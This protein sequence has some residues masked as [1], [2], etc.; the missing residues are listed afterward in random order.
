VNI[1][2]T[3]NVI[4]EKDSAVGS[5]SASGQ[6]NIDAI[7][8]G[9]IGAV[10]DVSGKIF[11]HSANI[12]TA[13][14]VL[15]IVFILEIP[16]NVPVDVDG[17]G[18][19]VGDWLVLSG[20]AG[21]D[22]FEVNSDSVHVAGRTTISYQGISRL[23]IESLAGTDIFDVS[24]TSALELTKL[25]GTGS[26]SLNL[27]TNGQ[28]NR[29]L[30]FNGGS[31]P[32]PI[33]VTAGSFAPGVFGENALAASSSRVVGLGLDLLHHN[34]TSIDSDL[35]SP[36][37][38]FYLMDAV[39][40]TTVQANANHHQVVIGGPESVVLAIAGG[41]TRT[42]SGLQDLSTFAKPVTL[43]GL[44]GAD[45]SLTFD[46]SKGRA[47]TDP[48]DPGQTPGYLYLDSL[49]GMG[50]G[51]DAE[52]SFT[53][54][55]KLTVDIGDGDL[56]IVETI[57][58]RVMVNMGPGDESTLTGT[59]T[60]TVSVLSSDA[61]ELLIT[62]GGSF[63][64]VVVDASSTTSSLQA[65]VEDA[66][67]DGVSGWT[68][69]DGFDP[70]GPTYI[71]GVT[72]AEL[73][74]GSDNDSLTISTSVPTMAITAYG[75]TGADQ[76][77]VL[78]NS[79]PED[80]LSNGGFNLSLFG[81]A[82]E[83]TVKAI[84]PGL[85]NDPNHLGLLHV[86]SN[87]E[88]LVIDNT[89]NSEKVD[90]ETNSGANVGYFTEA[91]GH[92]PLISMA[93]VE[94]V[95]ILGGSSPTNTL[96]I[97]AGA[98]EQKGTIDGN[99]VTLR[100]SG[101]LQF[102]RLRGPVASY[103]EGSF[104]LRT[105]D[106]S[107]GLIEDNTLAPAVKRATDQDVPFQLN[108]TDGGLF[109]LFSI[110]LSGI[111][112]T[113][114]FGTRADGSTVNQ[115]IQVSSP[116]EFTTYELGP[117]FRN[118]VSVIFSPGEF[119]ITSIVATQT[120]RAGVS[121][122]INEVPGF[123]PTEPQDIELFG[124]SGIAVNGVPVDFYVISGDGRN[125]RYGIFNG[126][127][128][129]LGN[130]NLA[131]QGNARTIF[132]YGDLNIPAN[133]TVTLGTLFDS[134]AVSIVVQNDVNIGEGVVFNVP[135]GSLGGGRGGSVESTTGSGPAG[136]D[137]NDF[138]HALDLHG[139]ANGGTFY[140]PGGG[141]G[142]TGTSWR[143][144]SG[145]G[146]NFD[147]VGP[148]EID[149]IGGAGGNSVDNNGWVGGV[150]FEGKFGSE[151]RN[152]VNSFGSAG[153]TGAGGAGGAGGTGGAPAG[154]NDLFGYP[155]ADGAP[156]GDGSPG[157]SGTIVYSNSLVLTA[158]G[159][160]GSGGSGGGG[161]AGGGG[162]LGPVISDDSG[163][164]SYIEGHWGGPGGVGG[165]G[166]Q[167]GAGGG[168]FA[169]RAA[170]RI[171]LNAT[172]LV[173]R[174]QDGQAGT[175]GA[176]GG[177]P[178]DPNNRTVLGTYGD[179]GQGGTGG[180]GGNGG[181][182]AGGGG[183]TVQ[184]YG[185]AVY[186]GENSSVD[187]GGGL[188]GDGTS[189]GM[190]G[191]FLFGSNTNTVTLERLNVGNE[192][193]YGLG[194]NASNP[195]VDYDVYLAGFD[196]PP[197]SGTNLMV[198]G[199]LEGGDNNYFLHVYD[200]MGRR[201]VD[202]T[203]RS[204]VDQDGTYQT[205]FDL[206]LVL[207]QNLNSSGTVS[208]ETLR[209]N[210]ISKV[211]NVANIDPVTPLIGG[212]RGGAN[213][214]G[215]VADPDLLAALDLNVLYESAISNAPSD[216]LATVMRL[217]MP[218]GFDQYAGFDLVVYTNLTSIPL[219]N[220]RLGITQ[221]SQDSSF[222]R[223]LQYAGSYQVVGQNNFESFFHNPYT[224]P[225]PTDSLVVGVT[226]TYSGLSQNLGA[227]P[228]HGIF[229]TLI[230][231]E[232]LREDQDS[233][234]SDNVTVGGDGVQCDYVNASISGAVSNVAGAILVDGNPLYITLPPVARPDSA[235]QRVYS[236]FF[237]SMDELT[238]TATGI[239]N[240][241]I[242]QLHS[243]PVSAVTI[244]LTA[245]TGNNEVNLLEFPPSSGT[246]ASQTI[247]VYTGVGTD[248]VTLYAAQAD[249]TFNVNTGDASD[250]FV[251][252]G[253]VTKNFRN[254][255]RVELGTGDDVA[256]VTSTNLE[257]SQDILLD[258]GPD[259]DRLDY[260]LEGNE[261]VARDADNVLVTDPVFPNGSITLAP[262][263]IVGTVNYRN[264]EGGFDGLSGPESDPGVYTINQGES[265]TLLGVATA[266][267]NSQILAISWDLDGDGFYGDAFDPATT[268]GSEAQSNPVV[269]WQRLKDLGLGLADT[270]IISMEVT[271][272]NGDFVEYT[273][274]TVNRVAPVI[275][276]NAPDVV[277]VGDNIAA[278]LG[279]FFVGGERPSVASIVWDIVGDNSSTPLPGAATSA[280]H[281]YRNVGTYQ[282][283]A[284]FYEG[285]NAYQ[286]NIEE[287]EVIVDP[288]SLQIGGPYTIL[289]GDGVVL[290]AI[291]D[292][293]PDQ[294]QWDL[295]G[296]GDYL[297]S[298]AFVD[299]GNGTSTSSIALFWS[300]LNAAGITDLGTFANVKVRA[301]YPSG[302]AAGF[303]VS[304][305]TSLTVNDVAPTAMLTGGPIGEGGTGSVT[306][307]RLFHPSPEVTAAGFRYSYDFGNTG[308]YQVVDSSS[309]T[310]TIP[311]ELLYQ[312]GS[313]PVRGRI[314][315][316]FGTASEYVI[317]V[318]I[319]D[320][321]PAFVTFDGGKIVN[322]GETVS[323]VNVS[324]TDPGRDII[325]ATINWGDGTSTAG[326]VTLTNTNPIPTTGT[327]SGSHTF[328][329]R[330]APYQVSVTITDVSGLSATRTFE[331]TVLDPVLSSVVA[332]PDQTIDE[333]DEVVLTAAR[334]I[335]PAAPSNYSVS[336]DWGDGTVNNS[337]V[338]SPPS[339]P[340]DAGRVFDGHYYGQ[341]GVYVVKMT[342]TKVGQ[343]PIES[344]FN[345]IV[346]NVIP[347]VDAGEDVAAGPGVPVLVNATFSDPSFLDSYVATID[348][349]DGTTS[350]GAI[351]LSPGSEGAPT[352]GIVT[353]S[354]Q[355][356][357]NGPHTVTVS[358]GD[359]SGDQGS[360][361]FQVVN[362][363]PEI[364]L[365]QASLEDVEGNEVTLS[366][367]FTDL[368]FDY[369]GTA[370][371]FTASIDWGDGSSVLA[372]Y[373]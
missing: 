29:P 238:V 365:N 235:E 68:K 116:G 76:F 4:L 313:L 233:C 177:V 185:T 334:F 63:N 9:Q 165:V 288:A 344:T 314:A 135:P 261:F 121:R 132:F 237:S 289:A 271:T 65:S 161:G 249:H 220:P 189:S 322:V 285:G 274:L 328:A 195:D 353:G 295:S 210:I 201:I 154:E 343:D 281:T 61:T 1:A 218:D 175:P 363:Q 182:G 17:G 369:S 35:I 194:P 124:G 329:Y 79:V 321:P 219:A 95:D 179:S 317:N 28:F 348:W 241:V 260:L 217:D 336:V 222:L 131:D 16:A 359:G 366:G 46:N 120:L 257:T 153:A 303:L 101:L 254:T 52:F 193:D 298:S 290:T 70:I 12:T 304:Q 293:A 306:F 106:G 213:T 22:T 364:T 40:E 187:V 316:Q 337:P 252:A 5:N 176:A 8:S 312:V 346:N 191:Q 45:N 199:L 25:T 196:P 200:G 99:K 183:G 368:G 227:L 81:A 129:A 60:N 167:G 36:S 309:P 125:R 80:L 148:L 305:P 318:P 157:T 18:G 58:G 49:E 225:E 98:V 361:T 43:T 362:S 239:K 103:S 137:P 350:P 31:G 113:S 224:A 152:G 108:A 141:A 310:H 30:E 347:R 294:A 71:K 278:S 216:A 44:P 245:N 324:F 332:G 117:E 354:H 93:R 2:T 205:A 301:N 229:V 64:R 14:N 72:E 142:G 57:P 275:T 231:D 69:L 123:M 358:V 145:I 73:Y 3:G 184:L 100:S 240:D 190:D 115:S 327:I 139:G 83:D 150:G 265:V 163:T 24:G 104:T 126:T 114:F 331:V 140:G 96:T 325:S 158:G 34:A 42:V 360:D 234:A 277:Y 89:A 300:Q 118:L 19:N 66:I 286:S 315:D 282:V 250:L 169:I 345:V 258:G 279:A 143:T 147:Y 156:G 59:G 119:L 138:A 77:D 127:P 256:R 188:H 128:F 272:T 319:N 97:N 226:P 11:A 333:G 267:T 352:T 37:S 180:A 162:G 122:Q 230:P 243:P 323:L 371:S 198:L 111:G 144:T 349:G 246:S 248:K 181:S 133:S 202:V 367:S 107:L 307:T 326:A 54:F 155:G 85:P 92:T 13:E 82:G 280:S 160:G 273:T 223:N 292:G 186:A 221:G 291:A 7:V 284:T 74:L 197:E 86:D 94:D 212:L 173:A 209:E 20:T 110:D 90:W 268:P 208:D 51:A 269:S 171:N 48:N 253:D 251:L 351:T 33:Q 242:N 136:N 178:Q 78:R 151:P 370:K 206:Y 259:F 263:T 27:S 87:V 355:Y 262:E 102:T 134:Q 88:H 38:N 91:G 264:F 32:N 47:G 62:G 247:N 372:Q 159:G 255:F 302:V 203:R 207:V 373:S 84:I 211:A 146:Y 39:A 15:D 164:F 168:A 287:I 340:L 299:N 149:W 266:A 26:A 311:P 21:N 6:V 283:Q 23:E 67:R 335:D 55:D 170:G 204:L 339:N 270:Y 228:A 356:A 41:G 50:E 53:G 297:Y 75:G 192:F 341:D 244:D 320:L 112:N 10:V 338:V 342:V 357:G 130:G 236:V 308:T 276:L 105:I 174:G 109:S 214:Y 56:A 330:P 215:L 166:G 232:G 172:S 296:Q